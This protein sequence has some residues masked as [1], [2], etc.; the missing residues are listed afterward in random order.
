MTEYEKIRA[1]N[2]M[3]NNRRLQSMGISALVSMVRKRSNFHEVS[4]VTCEDS[5]SVIT[6]G[7]GSE[8]SPK[9]DEVNHQDESDDTLV[10]QVKVGVCVRGGGG[11][12]CVLSVFM[13]ALNSMQKKFLLI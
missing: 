6:Q 3:R 1:E 11:I 10:K 4:A 13:V 7:S 2:M 9:D 12:L 5:A 8:Y